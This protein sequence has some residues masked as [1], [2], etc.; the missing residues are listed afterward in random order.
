MNLLTARVWK[1]ITHSDS[2]HFFS[3]LLEDATG[4]EVAEALREWFLDE[5]EKI[6][7]DDSVPTIL[8]SL[9]ESS[10]DQVDWDYLGEK[11]EEFRDA[12]FE[13]GGRV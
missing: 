1:A 8:T 13:Y 6:N 11:W 10:L 2:L 3:A 9:L 4:P 5:F 12:V 7:F